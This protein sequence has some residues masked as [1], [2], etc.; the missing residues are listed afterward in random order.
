MGRFKYYTLKYAE[1]MVMLRKRQMWICSDC[2]WK[3]SMKR[4]I[5]LHC[6]S[7][8]VIGSDPKKHHHCLTPYISRI[9]KL[10]KRNCL[11]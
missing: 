3:S 1:A 4:P 11:L 6:V 2:G 5:M 9:K 7:D 10:R 8:C